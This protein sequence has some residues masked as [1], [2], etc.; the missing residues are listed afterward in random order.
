MK[1]KIGA[2]ALLVSDYDEAIRFFTQKLRFSLVEDKV[3]KA[4]KRW[5]LVSPADGD[6]CCLLLAKAATPCQ[7]TRIGDQ[8]G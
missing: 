5:V 1:Q 2:I 6:G 8:T 3:L 4:G 7:E